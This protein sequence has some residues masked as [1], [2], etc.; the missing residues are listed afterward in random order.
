MAM[1]PSPD[2]EMWVEKYVPLLGHALVRKAHMP[3]WRFPPLLA[4]TGWELEKPPGP[5]VQAGVDMAEPLS[6]GLLYKR[7]VNFLLC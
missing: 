4:G 7:E 3:S 1:G 2:K 6:S 5:E